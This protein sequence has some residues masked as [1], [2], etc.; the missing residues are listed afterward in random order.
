MAQEVTGDLFDYWREGYWIG[1]TTN[2]SVRRD[3]KAVMGRGVAKQ[4]ADTMPGL[5][6]AIG[7][8]LLDPSHVGQVLIFSTWRIVSIPVKHHW[9]E[10]ADIFLIERSLSQLAHRCIGW[11]IPHLV[12]PRPGCGNGGLDWERDG[13]RILTHQYLDGRFTIVERNP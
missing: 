10:Q 4:A 2:G 6:R 7:T 8:A 3:G 1:I 13:V 11:E 12:L 5:Q 9:A